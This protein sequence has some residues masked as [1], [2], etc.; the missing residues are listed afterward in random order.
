[1]YVFLVIEQYV[2]MNMHCVK[3]TGASRSCQPNTT[4]AASKKEIGIW[5]GLFYFILHSCSNFW[6]ILS[7]Y[8]VA[9]DRCASF[10]QVPVEY[11]LLKQ[12]FAL[13]SSIFEEMRSI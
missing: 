8:S 9:K 13:N 11:K 4:T 12:T 5:F 10:K 3:L 1:M 6:T 2:Y 7:M